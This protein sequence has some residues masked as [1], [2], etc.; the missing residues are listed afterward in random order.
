MVDPPSG[1]LFGFPKELPEG[2]DLE[3]LLRESGYPEQHIE[4]AM[5]YTRQWWE[6]EE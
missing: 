5:K 1:Y 3:E 2:G 4:F 6:E